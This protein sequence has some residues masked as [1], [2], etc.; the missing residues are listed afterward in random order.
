MNNQLPLRT[1]YLELST[2]YSPLR[3]RHSALRRPLFVPRSSF[4]ASFASLGEDFVPAPR[5]N[6]DHFAPPSITNLGPANDLPR[7]GEAKS[8][9]FRLT[10]KKKKIMRD[11]TPYFETLVLRGY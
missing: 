7:R 4:P 10:E 8:T 9:V 2:P 5:R 1:S 6:P 3:L 11:E